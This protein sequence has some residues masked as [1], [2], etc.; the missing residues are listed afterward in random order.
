MEST[1]QRNT[2]RP[3]SITAEEWTGLWQARKDLSQELHRI[4]EKMSLLQ[5]A[6]REWE[7][8]RDALFARVQ[9][10]AKIEE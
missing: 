3:A 5:E 9:L 10:G 4:R 8:W 7:R 2:N 1:P 6:E